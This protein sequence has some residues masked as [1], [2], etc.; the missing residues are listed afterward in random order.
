[1]WE[2]PTK[3]PE[4]TQDKAPEVVQKKPRLGKKILKTLKNFANRL[5]NLFRNYWS[6]GEVSLEEDYHWDKIH[7]NQ[8]IWNQ[9]YPDYATPSGIREIKKLEEKETK[10]D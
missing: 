6:H 9:D 8:Q 10:K 5:D 7:G 3:A 4:T 1:M 2:T